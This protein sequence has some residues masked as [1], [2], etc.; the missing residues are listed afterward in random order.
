MMGYSLSQTPIVPAGHLAALEKTIWQ[1]YDA[2]CNSGVVAAQRE[3]VHTVLN[4]VVEGQEAAAAGK[5]Y[6]LSLLCLPHTKWY[7]FPIC[8][9]FLASLHLDISMPNQVHRSDKGSESL[10]RV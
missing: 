6:L 3:A 10:K 9:A 4:M 2:G 1:Q 5:E 8:E 7:A